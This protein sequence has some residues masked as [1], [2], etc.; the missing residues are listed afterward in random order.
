MNI[1][2]S[3]LIGILSSI[4]FIVVLLIGFNGIAL[5][6]TADDT[7]TFIFIAL[8]VTAII[9]V[10][11]FVFDKVLAGSVCG[12]ILMAG[13]LFLFNGSTKGTG[14]ENHD[15]LLYFLSIMMVLSYFI[16]LLFESIF[17]ER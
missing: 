15:T 12:I 5:E 3:R 7:Y 4:V 10:V 8:F 6:K 13:L 16:G 2:I 1:L 11:F 14:L 17:K 9:G